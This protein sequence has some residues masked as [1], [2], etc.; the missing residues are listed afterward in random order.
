[1]S[2]DVDNEKL[3]S[4]IVLSDA[5]A[6]LLCTDAGDAFFRGFIVENRKTHEVTL[7]FRFSYRDGKRSWYKVTSK[8]QGEAAAG[9]LR[10]GISDVLRTGYAAQHGDAL[11]ED[12]IQ[13]FDPPDDH[14]DGQNTIKWLLERDLIEVYVEPVEEEK[15]RH[16]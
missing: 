4:H 15:E 11:P 10:D 5:Y 9:H 2:W 13:Y 3:L 7:K 12:A 8:L 14:G 16:A 6:D 1:M